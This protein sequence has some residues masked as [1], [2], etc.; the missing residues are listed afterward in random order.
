MRSR[1]RRLVPELAGTAAIAAVAPMIVLADGRSARLATALWIVMVA[2]SV[3]SMPFVRLQIDR[4]RH[5]PR[6]VATSDRA[7]GAAVLLA[8]TACLVDAHVLTAMVIVVRNLFRLMK[9]F[10]SNC[11]WS[12]TTCKFERAMRSK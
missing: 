9:L 3:A 6:P 1:S 7:Q 8:V 11:T 4:L 2:R 5:G 10:F 12:R